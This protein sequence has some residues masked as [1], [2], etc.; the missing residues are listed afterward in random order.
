IFSN[1]G[2]LT[3]LHSS[4]P[5]VAIIAC[6]ILSDVFIGKRSYLEKLVVLTLI[7]APFYI[8]TSLHDWNFTYFDV[9]PGKANATIDEGFGKGIRTN[10]VFKNLYDWIRVTSDSYTK[11]DDYILSYVTSPMVHM[12]AKRRP[13]LDDP[14][15]NFTET[16][17]DYF[18][19]AIAFMKAHRRE[20]KLAF[21]FAAQPGLTS[22]P[23]RGAI[24]YVWFGDQ[25]HFPS[26]DPLSLYVTQNMT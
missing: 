25:F 8:T 2:V 7:L 6:L 16:P 4:I 10:D 20:P 5:A 19:K 15:I 14:F 12:I 18:I 1:L 21:V 3:V 26:S 13:A 23:S 24:G 22:I 17:H 9:E 11:K